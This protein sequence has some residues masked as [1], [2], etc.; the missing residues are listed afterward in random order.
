MET[1]EL[2]IMEAEESSDA[3]AWGEHFPFT[4]DQHDFD[5]FAFEVWRQGCCPEVAEEEV[6]TK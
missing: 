1:L 6:S 4:F 3:A 5:A 2:P